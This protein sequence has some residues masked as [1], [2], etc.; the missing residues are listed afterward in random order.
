M[1]M[2]SVREL[3][4]ALP[5][6]TRDPFIDDLGDVP[7]SRGCGHVH[8]FRSSEQRTR[9]LASHIAQPDRPLSGRS[10]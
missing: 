7:V 2:P 1:I 8:A 10:H 6:V 9:V 4:P 3:R 5:I